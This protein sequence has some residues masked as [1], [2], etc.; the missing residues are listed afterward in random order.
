MDDVADRSPVIAPR[1]ASWRIE[2]KR[3]QARK[4]SFCEPEAMIRCANLTTLKDLITNGSRW[5]TRSCIL[6]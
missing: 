5:E 4:L 6:T 2:Q 1:H 3:L